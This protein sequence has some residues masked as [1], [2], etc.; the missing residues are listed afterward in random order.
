[1]ISVHLFTPN[2]T[3]PTP[4]SS[5]AFTSYSNFKASVLFM[6]GVDTWEAG[7]LRMSM[8]SGIV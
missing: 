8:W 6:S 7:I 3:P 1:M 2:A 5:T 4:L